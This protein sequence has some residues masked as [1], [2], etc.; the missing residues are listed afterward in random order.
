M[1]KIKNLTVILNKKEILKDINLN[2][3]QGEIYALLGP[4][5]SGKSTLAK[6]IL[7]FP[8]YKVMSQ[9]LI[10]QLNA[11]DLTK[12]D[13][14]KRSQAG[15]FLSFQNPPEIDGISTLSFLRQLKQVHQ[16]IPHTSLSNFKKEIKQYFKELNL[17]ESILDRYLNVGF[18]GGEKKRLEL[19]QAKLANPKLAIFDE[20]DSG[21]DI[22]G[23]KVIAKE[24]KN[25]VKKN[26]TAVLLITHNGRI[27]DYLKPDKILVMIDGQIVKTGDKS[28]VKLIEEKGYE[29]L[30]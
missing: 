16:P 24:I 9:N 5:G 30:K 12:L 18:S 29:S 11:E 10:M 13:M 14:T 21:I 25:L 27:I 20:I 23:L 22:Q 1:L 4:N 19:V 15:I 2:I 3:K 8:Q 26:K 6:T 7:G 17:D 28:L